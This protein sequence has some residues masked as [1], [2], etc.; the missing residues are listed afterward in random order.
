MEQSPSTE[1]KR[2]SVSQ[3]IPT[4][5]GYRS[6]YYRIYHSP[7]PVSISNQINSVHAPTPFLKNYFN[8]ILTS[9]HRSSKRS[10]SVRSS[11][12]KSVYTSSVS[13]TCHLPCPSYLKQYYLALLSC[14]NPVT[15]II[16]VIRHKRFI[17]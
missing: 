17:N 9:T 11:H 2:S 12:Q 5:Y 16:K 6:V 8:I 4:F 15:I 14:W 1:A 10:L 13:H 7:P 3:E